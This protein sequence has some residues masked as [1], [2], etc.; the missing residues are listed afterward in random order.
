MAKGEMGVLV[1][2]NRAGITKRKRPN[3]HMCTDMK[4]IPVHMAPI[5]L[6]KEATVYKCNFCGA[7]KTRANIPYSRAK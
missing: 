1:A 3:C 7:E 5:K 2:R 6:T 4:K